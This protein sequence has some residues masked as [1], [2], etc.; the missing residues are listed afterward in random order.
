MGSNAEENVMSATIVF[1]SCAKAVMTQVREQ[2]PS[3]EARLCEL[4]GSER[5]EDGWLQVQ[6]QNETEAN[7]YTVRASLVL[8]SATLTAEALDENAG[9][10]LERVT[11][12]LAQLVRQ[13]MGAETPPASAADEV[14]L[15]SADSFPAS[16][17]PAWTHVTV[18]G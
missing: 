18:S 13:H 5:P 15:A 7:R 8:P 2:W 3:H 4:F 11:E 12:V 16:D 10:A 17:P 9:M 14:E 6:V 1:K